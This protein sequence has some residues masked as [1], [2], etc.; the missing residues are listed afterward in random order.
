MSHFWLTMA[1]R[2]LTNFI[3]HSSIYQT[4]QIF[5]SQ[6]A[7]QVWVT[8]IESNMDSA[9]SHVS[10]PVSIQDYGVACVVRAAVFYVRA[11]DEVLGTHE[12]GVVLQLI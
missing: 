8:I 3:K 12:L 2:T 4:L 5:P 9:T 7:L 1:I 6:A 11:K 10:T